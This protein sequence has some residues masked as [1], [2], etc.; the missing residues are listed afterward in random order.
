MSF[1]KVLFDKSRGFPLISDR[2]VT[3]DF[4]LRLLQRSHAPWGELAAGV[5]GFEPVSVYGFR[6]LPRTCRPG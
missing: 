4:R 2:L 3:G 5:E 1:L 6:I